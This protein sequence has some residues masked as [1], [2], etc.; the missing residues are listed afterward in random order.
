M[1]LMIFSKK[2][3]KKPNEEITISDKEQ[4]QLE[5]GGFN[6]QKSNLEH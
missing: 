6:Q 5:E 4:G 3:K 2:A 1:L